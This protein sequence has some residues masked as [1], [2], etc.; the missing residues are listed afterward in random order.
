MG[1]TTECCF[2]TTIR[3]AN[4]R[5]FECCG[6]EEATAGY[7]AEFK[8]PT[9]DMISWSEGLFGFVGS[10]QSLLQ[11]LTPYASHL[12]INGTST[13]PRTPPGWDGQVDIS[14]L[15]IQYRAG[16]SPVTVI[17]ALY[18]RIEK[19]LRKDP[20]VWIH[21]KS[22]NELL[23]A[24]SKLAE[25]FLDHNKLPTLYGVPFRYL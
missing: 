15:Q 19:Y 5:G 7:N 23:E 10:L 13:P 12:A 14:S 8:N 25:K 4:D 18:G 24:A 1:V 11:A 2:S 21:L 22:K 6:I 3:E 9:L 17:E 20:A 16:L